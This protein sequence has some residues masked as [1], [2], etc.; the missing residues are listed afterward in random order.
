MSLAPGARLIARAGPILRARLI[1]RSSHRAGFVSGMSF[2][3]GARLIN[4]LPLRRFSA[5]REVHTDSR[6]PPAP[7]RRV[8]IDSQRRP[9][10]NRRV[11][12][13]SRRRLAA[14]R[15]VRIDLAIFHMLA[16]ANRGFITEQPP[17]CYMGKTKTPVQ[18]DEGFRRKV[19]RLR[20]A[21]RE[22]PK[23]AKSMRTLQSGATGCGT[24]VIQHTESKGPHFHATPARDRL[25]KEHLLLLVLIGLKAHMIASASTRS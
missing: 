13:D 8:R 2:A 17:I 25:A 21:V 12:I 19:R 11:R 14:D 3:P 5:D 1:G 9:A 10:S 7:D 18:S 4:A 6:H 22:G 15:G 16:T 24:D 23:L 20:F